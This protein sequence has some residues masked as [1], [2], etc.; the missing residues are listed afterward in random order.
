MVDLLWRLV[1]KLS[2][3]IKYG[4]VGSVGFGIHLL[5]L[6]LLTEYAHLWYMLSATIA[7][8]V[9]ALNNYILNYHWTFKDK[10]A[11]IHN[12][13]AGYFQY[14]L[15]RG[16]TEGLYLALLYLMVDIVGFHYLVSAV[17]V[18]VVTA[19]VGY[20]IAVKWIWRRRKYRAKV[21]IREKMVA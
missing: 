4:L 2:G 9:A 19:V 20:M 13:V 17:L 1:A 7:I 14:L 11:N 18:Q 12:K 10:K 15:S 8:V 21:V 6:W 5:V 3:F 16:F